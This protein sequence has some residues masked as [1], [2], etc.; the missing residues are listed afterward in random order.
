MC[1]AGSYAELM[2][3]PAWAGTRLVAATLS[4]PAGTPPPG[5]HSIENYAH[6]ACELGRNVGADVVVGFSLGGSVAREMVTSG[7]FAGPVVLPGIGPSATD[8]PAFFNMIVWLGS[9]VGSLP[10][11]VLVKGAASVVKRMPA[12]S[13]VHTCNV[14]AA[15]AS[16]DSSA[17]GLGR[18]EAELT[19]PAAFTG[20]S[21]AG[22]WN[23]QRA[24]RPVRRG[25]D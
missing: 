22:V 12:P 6:L 4:G 3:E 2:A 17:S 5:D 13:A 10:V 15:A 19:P 21:A 16:A 7:D 11:T 24:T 8:E 1:S 18:A 14:A 9:V 25:S 20:Q 23:R